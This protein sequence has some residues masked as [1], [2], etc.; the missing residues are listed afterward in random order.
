VAE[1]T[2]AKRADRRARLSPTQN[3]KIYRS[4]DVSVFGGQSSGDGVIHG[5][6]RAAVTKRPVFSD[7][8]RSSDVYYQNE[9]ENAPRRR[10]QATPVVRKLPAAPPVA[11]GEVIVV[12]AADQ[13][14]EAVDTAVSRVLAGQSAL[15]S[16]PDFKLVQRV[17]TAADQ[18]IGQGRLT[19][20]QRL[21]IAIVHVTPAEAEKAETTPPPV[22]APAEQDPP[23]AVSIPFEKI[24]ESHILGEEVPRPEETFIESV[25]ESS[26]QAETFIGETEADVSTATDAPSDAAASEVLAAPAEEVVDEGTVR[27]TPTRGRR[28]GRGA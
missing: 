27:R 11:G 22:T 13:V 15:I 9:G 20:E 25:P 10:A 4:R 23:A 12:T 2:D 8:P 5:N 28:T 24:P 14:R 26:A 21:S 17:R 3:D 19:E 7:V 1:M 6:K 18:L 16:A